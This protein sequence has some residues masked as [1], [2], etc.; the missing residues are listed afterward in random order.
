MIKCL[1]LVCYSVYIV[2]RYLLQAV[3]KTMRFVCKC[4][5]ITGSCSLRTCWKE[6]AKFRKIGR[7]IKR[8]YQHALQLDWNEK[9]KDENDPRRRS[10]F[11]VL[12]G[13]SMIYIEHSPDYCKPNKTLGIPGTMNR[14]CSRRHKTRKVPRSE[15]R[16]CRNVC[17]VCGYQVQKTTVEIL[18]TC[19]CKFKWCCRV[20]CDTCVVYEDRYHCVK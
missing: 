13:S 14:Q 4:H 1:Q 16:S 5:G 18:S 17:R 15:R 19:N 6:L 7:Y 11:P 2:L 3:T 9:M 20:N 12:P 10:L 8:K